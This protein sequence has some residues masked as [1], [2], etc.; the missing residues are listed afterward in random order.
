MLM[1]CAAHNKDSILVMNHA[2]ELYALLGH[3]YDSQGCLSMS[4]AA[5]P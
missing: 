3:L 5:R 2:G 1:S 4:V